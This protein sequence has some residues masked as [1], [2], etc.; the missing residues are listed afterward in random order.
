MCLRSNPGNIGA[1]FLTRVKPNEPPWPY[2]KHGSLMIG[3]FPSADSMSGHLMVRDKDLQ[4]FILKF[5]YY[6]GSML[7]IP[8]PYPAYLVMIS[9]INLLH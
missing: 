8:F 2:K 6:L 5:P 4:I 7:T 1:T 9:I 3:L